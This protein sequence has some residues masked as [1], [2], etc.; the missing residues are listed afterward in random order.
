MFRAL[1][2][3]QELR[4]SNV[5]AFS[6]HSLIHLLNLDVLH[7]SWAGL[8]GVSDKY[9]VYRAYAAFCER[10]SR[11]CQD[12]DRKHSW[13]QLAADWLFLIRD[14]SPAD[15][16]SGLPKT[17]GTGLAGGEHPPPTADV[18]GDRP[19]DAGKSTPDR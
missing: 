6:Q 3:L 7:A 15:S 2:H 8:L 16:Q 14:S 11:E 13:L 10:M 18:Q 5:T 1:H 17:G 4:L 19:P 9:N 12:E